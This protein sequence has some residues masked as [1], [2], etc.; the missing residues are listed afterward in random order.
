MPRVSRYRLR[1]KQEKELTD[2]FI[3]FISLLNGKEN[4]EDFFSQFLTTE[5]KIMLIKRLV[6]LLLLE[7]GEHYMAIQGKLNMSYETIR[8]YQ[9]RLP[10]KTKKFHVLLRKLLQQNKTKNFFTGIEKTLNVLSALAT[11]KTNMKSR[12]KILSG[13]Y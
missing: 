6:L 13:K 3:Y 7:K 5:E 4:I 8:T 1:E 10:F 9:H 2:E 12:S 11:S